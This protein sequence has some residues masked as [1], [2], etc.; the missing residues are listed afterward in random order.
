MNIRGPMSPCR[1]PRILAGLAFAFA[2]V[3]AGRADA[4][5]IQSLKTDPCHEWMMLGVLGE[6]R[7]PFSSP[8][9]P[10][11]AELFGR[12]AQRADR[13]GVPED[14]ATRAFIDALAQRF[15]FEDRSLAERFILA[16]FVAG[17]RQPDTHGWGIVKFNEIRTVHLL[18]SNQRAHSLRTSSQ[19]NEDGELAAIIDARATVEQ[20]VESA[21][22]LWRAPDAQ[23]IARWTFPHYGESDVAVFGPAFQLGRAIH[24]LQDAFAHTLRDEELRIEAVANFTESIQQEYYE[25][26]DGPA[27]SNRLDK[28]DVYDNDFDAMRIAAARDAGAGLLAVI[29]PEFAIEDIGAD[30]GAPAIMVAGLIDPVLDEAFEFR[31]GCTYDNDY[32]DSAWTPIAESDITQPYT[33]VFCSSTE[34]GPTAPGRSV[35]L[36]IAL[37]LVAAGVRILRPERR[38]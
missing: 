19:D 10:S 2:M 38:R 31:S 36:G 11:T 37:L 25:P 9:A 6:M 5:Y 4:F 1:G 26:R 22:K 32:C 29:T 23:M 3:W 24:V 28:C 14:E 17:V 7:E 20:R 27:H 16:S 21:L 18:E 15:D 33:L 30:M 35:P 13:S 34:S 8:G 12:F